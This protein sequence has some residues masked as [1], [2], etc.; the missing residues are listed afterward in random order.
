MAPQIDN[1][2]G[3]RAFAAL[4]VVLLHIR[5]G[6][7]A[8]R[9]GPL[10]FLFNNQALGVDVFFV[11]SGLIIGHVHGDDFSKGL[12]KASYR[13][14]LWARLA[15]ICPVHLFMLAMVA[16]VLPLFGVWRWGPADSYPLLLANLVLVHAWGVTGVLSFN[17]VSWT[18]SAE[19]L[20]Y[21]CFPLLARRS[22]DLP[23]WCFLV[24]AVAA[25]L[26]AAEIPADGLS[27]GRLALKGLLLFTSGFCWFRFGAAP[28][29]PVL[30]YAGAAAIG[31]LLILAYWLSVPGFIWIF[32][33][34]LGPWILCLF[35]SR[36]I[37]LYA[38][39]VS[40]YLG[41]L[42][43]SLYMS[44]SVAFMVF[45]SWIGGERPLWI[46]LPLVIAVAAAIYHLI[47][48]PARQFIRRLAAVAPGAGGSSFTPA[49]S[50]AAPSLL[51]LP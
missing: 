7:A 3:L 45:R 29:N 4:S 16:G 50:S 40:L 42:S 39:P 1:L 10:A 6:V 46:E 27:H 47:E 11:L 5:Y 22:K 37:F 51:T 38:N 32:E 15:K 18:I 31:P 8:D 12:T 41:R 36:P 43:Y 44:H 14:F 24:L 17:A 34:A 20:A 25:A 33:A 30:C 26:S 19:W 9:F 28:A 23:R 35:K 49:K 13:S 48:Q 2:T 21:L